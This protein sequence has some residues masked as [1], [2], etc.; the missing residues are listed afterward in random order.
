VAHP[1]TQSGQIANGSRQKNPPSGSKT[2]EE[3]E[4]Q[5]DVLALPTSDNSFALGGGFAE[6][7]LH[8]L[9]LFNLDPRGK[10]DNATLACLLLDRP[11]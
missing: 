8:S 1:V 4:F 9:S 6:V 2:A 10:R 3:L 5:G 7:A 11:R